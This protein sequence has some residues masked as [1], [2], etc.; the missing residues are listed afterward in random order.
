MSKALEILRAFLGQLGAGPIKQTG[1]LEPLLAGAWDSF[2]LSNAGGMKAYKLHGRM[3]KLHWD[4][5]ILSF[6]IERHGATVMRSKKGE[7]QR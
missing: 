1:Q 5:P 4:P 7:L 6:T 2:E 3:E